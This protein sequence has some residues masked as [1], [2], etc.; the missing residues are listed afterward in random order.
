[1]SHKEILSSS[2]NFGGVE[3]NDFSSKEGE[4]STSGQGRGIHRSHSRG[5]GRGRRG[6][7]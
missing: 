3:E 7:D 4:S 2:P 1:M 5:R 6:G